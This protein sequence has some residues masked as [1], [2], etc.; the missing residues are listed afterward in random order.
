MNIKLKLFFCTLILL[1]IGCK[2]DFLKLT[3]QSSTVSASFYKT[4][5]DFIT[6]IN[7]AYGELQ[8]NTQY[9]YFFLTLME[10]RSDN[11]VDNQAATNSGLYYNIDRFNEGTSNSILNDTWL[12]IYATINYCNNVINK[13]EGIAIDD[14]SK[15]RLKGEATFIRGLCYFNATRLWGKV[16]IV[17]KELA[18][19]EAKQ[20]IRNEVTDVYKQIEADLTFASSNLPA[21]YSGNDI[22]RATSNAA[23]SLLGKVLLYE[24]KYDQAAV[25]LKQVIDAGVYQ[26]LPTIANVFSVGNKNN[27]EI[28]FAV[29]YKSGGV[30]EGHSLWYNGNNAGQDS[31]VEPKLKA[32]YSSQDKRLPLCYTITTGGTTIKVPAK[33]ADAVVSSETSNDF[34]V[35]R[36]SDV[37]LMYAECLNEMGYTANGTAFTFLNQVRIRAGIPTLSSVTVPDQTTFRMAVWNERRLEFAL[38]CDRWFDLVRTNQA[39]VAM[40]VVGRTIQSYQYLYAIPQNEI[41][42]INN[43]SNFPQNAGY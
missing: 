28:V 37:L 22:G 18:P 21:L 15:N 7:G 12:D 11:V 30:G 19:D 5:N 3:P 26:I 23:K 8:K 13:I 42:I 6:A 33:F 4:K 35:I 40:A 16:P 31:V 43:P 24:K 2:K 32:A 1:A 14:S 25:V 9:G 36:Y 29:K 38:E 34:P 10:V 20:Q 27:A 17:L 39:I 41:N